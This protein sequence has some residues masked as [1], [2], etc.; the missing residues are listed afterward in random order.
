MATGE[1]GNGV[2]QMLVSTDD[3]SA[4][5]LAGDRLVVGFVDDALHGH[6]RAAQIV[7]WNAASEIEQGRPL[8]VEVAAYLAAALRAAATSPKDA[9]RALGLVRRGAPKKDDAMLEWALAREV[10]TLLKPKDRIRGNDERDDG[11][12]IAEVAR[13]HRISPRTVRRHLA[14]HNR[15]KRE[16]SRAFDEVFDAQANN[17]ID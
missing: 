2:Q 16:F 17:S 13:R 12:A 7:L 6:T 10:E 15:K 3:D 8:A 14:A 5:L 1:L 11:S 9:A 4:R